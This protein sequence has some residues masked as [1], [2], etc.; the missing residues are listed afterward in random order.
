MAVIVK[1]AFELHQTAERL[2]TTILNIL[3]RYKPKIHD[4]AIEE[5]SPMRSDLCLIKTI[6]LRDSKEKGRFYLLCNAYVDARYKKEYSITLEV[7]TWLA[8]RV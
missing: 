6:P 1:A 7:L 2:Y 8:Q 5:D 4:L 3:T